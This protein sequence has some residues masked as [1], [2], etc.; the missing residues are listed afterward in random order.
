MVQPLQA[1]LT[2]RIHCSQHHVLKLHDEYNF[3]ALSSQ[4][5]IE[6]TVEKERR[7]QI[8][9]PDKTWFIYHDVA[10]NRYLIGNITPK[11]QPLHTFFAKNYLDIK[12]A[13]HCFAGLFKLY[14]KTCQTTPITLR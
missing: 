10:Q 9:H 14:F 5:W 1:V 4:R 8:Y 7:Y 6:Q 13:L 2:T 11:L 3:D 12:E